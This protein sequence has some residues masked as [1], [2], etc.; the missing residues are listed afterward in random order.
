MLG[1]IA[2]MFAFLVVASAI[3]Y[4]IS[5]DLQPNGTRLSFAMKVATDLVDLLAKCRDSIQNA[6]SE[7]VAKSGRAAHA[8]RRQS[9][10]TSNRPAAAAA[11]RS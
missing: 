6:G 9:V 3:T 5:W 1:F 10:E 7:S 11:V 4:W 8:S 2:M